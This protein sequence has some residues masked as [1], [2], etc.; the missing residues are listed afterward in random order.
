[1]EDYFVED[2][3]GYYLIQYPYTDHQIIVKAEGFHDAISQ[4][5]GH[6]RNAPIN[7]IKIDDSA[8]EDFKKLLEENK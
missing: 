2:M 4:C 8:V 7:V 1:M 6:N 5:E 3:A